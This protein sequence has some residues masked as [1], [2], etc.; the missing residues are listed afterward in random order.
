MAD[1]GQPARLIRPL[2]KA[3]PVKA[4]CFLELD[5]C[6]YCVFVHIHKPFYS[7]CHVQC[8]GKGLAAEHFPLP[9]FL[10]CSHS[11]KIVPLHKTIIL[12]SEEEL[13]YAQQ[14]IKCLLPPGDPAL[15]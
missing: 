3:Q 15:K 14:K 10:P 5:V 2:R 9:I 8:R 7:Q 12:F 13:E 4:L 11:K 6:F 1:Q